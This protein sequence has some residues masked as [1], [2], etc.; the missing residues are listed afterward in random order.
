[1]VVLAG[2]GCLEIGGIGPPFIVVKAAGIPAQVGV[3]L[4][5]KPIS[6]R[7]HCQDNRVPEAE[8]LA[9]LGEEG[10]AWLEASGGVTLEA[11]K[12]IGETGVE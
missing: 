12:A 11:L 9:V 6:L 2:I 1:M 5:C 7:L 10:R 8:H 4:E 3:T